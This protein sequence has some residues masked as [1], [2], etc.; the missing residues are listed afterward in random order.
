MARIPLTGPWILLLEISIHKG[1]LLEV[2]NDSN[3]SFL[4]P[5]LPSWP[6]SKFANSFIYDLA[7]TFKDGFL[8][9]SLVS[10]YDCDFPHIVLTNDS[11]NAMRLGQGQ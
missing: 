4:S 6:F 1:L 7:F 11:N 9:C 10:R 5:K 3:L 8:T 2:R